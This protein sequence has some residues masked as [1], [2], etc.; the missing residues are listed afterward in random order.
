[1]SRPAIIAGLVGVSVVVVLLL[2]VVGLLIIVLIVQLLVDA[3]TPLLLAAVIAIPQNATSVANKASPANVR[4]FET[5]KIV[6]ADVLGIDAHWS[7]LIGDG[8]N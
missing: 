3:V 8:S 1:M 2:L 4:A 7:P 5:V 6:P